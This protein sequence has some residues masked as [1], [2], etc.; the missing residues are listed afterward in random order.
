MINKYLTFTVLLFT[1]SLNAQSNFNDYFVYK[2]GDTIKCK[3]TKVKNQYI[4]FS[5]SPKNKF[6]LKRDLSKDLKARKSTLPSSKQTTYTPKSLRFYNCNDIFISQ[7]TFEKLKLNKIEKPKDGYSHIYF[8]RPYE[9]IGSGSSFYIREGDKKLLSLKTNSYYLLKVKA[10]SEHTYYTK[11]DLFTK[12]KVSIS[13]ENQKTYYINA[14]IITC[15]ATMGV[16]FGT[17]PPINNVNITNAKCGKNISLNEDKYSELQ[18]MSMY[19]KP[20]IYK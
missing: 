15:G 5:V 16:S 19:K 1:F 9:Y 11:R 6:I 18:V 2:N 8:Y 3:I 10:G 12:D 7:K 20:K 13:A 14:F 17:A 4:Y